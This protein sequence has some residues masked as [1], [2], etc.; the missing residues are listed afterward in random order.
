M[1]LDPQT[2]AFITAAEA[3]GLPAYHELP[4]ATEA[5]AL[6]RKLALARRGDGP[7]PGPR[8]S[9]EEVSRDGQWCRIYRP[10]E[11][12]VHDGPMPLVMFIHGGGW[13]IGDLETHDVQARAFAGLPAVVVSVDYRL[14]PEHP[15]PAAH[16][17][18]WAWLEWAAAGMGDWSHTDR[19][20]V[21]GDSAGGLL[22]ASMA[23]WCRDRE[24][25]PDLAAQCLVY[26]AMNVA[27]DTVSHTA[28]AEGYLLTHDVMRWFYDSYAPGEGFSPSVGVELAGLA[29]AVIATAGYDPLADDGIDYGSQLRAADV[30]CVN[31]HFDGLI[32]GFFGMGGVSAAA[33]G[34][35]EATVG[36]LRGL[37][38]R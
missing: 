38:N 20:V 27:M 23:Q 32:H 9:V 11:R 16:E 7:A 19:L 22:A 13:V 12:S 1:T 37:L 34:A 4:S 35:V 15:F 26:P 30:T 10:L 25:S 3:A 17:D 31:L 21:A 18:C 6:F 33:Q 5:R 2:A 24:D 14:A 28:N 36:A 8:V 29:P